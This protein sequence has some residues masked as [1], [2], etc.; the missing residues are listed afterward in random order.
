[1]CPLAPELEFSRALVHHLLNY[2]SQ[3]PIATIIKM[4]KRLACRLL[5]ATALP[6]LVSSRN[7]SG[8][9]TYLNPVLP[10]WHSDPSCINVD[11]TFFCVTSTFISFPGLPVYA[12]N[13][14][15]NWKLISHAWNREN[16]LPGL[17]WNTTGQQDGMYAPTIRY[18]DGIFYVICEYLGI[19]GGI[20]GTLF[21]TTDPFDDAS[22]SDPVMFR[23]THID[24]DLFW[25]DDGKVYMATH[26]ITMQELDIETGALT[27]EVNIWNGT[28]GVW[29]EGPHIYKRDGWYYLLIAEGGT[30]PDHAVTV[31]RS[32]D[33]YG[34]YEPSPFNPHLTNRGTDEWIQTVGHADLFQDG[35]GKWWG[36]ALGTR[37]GP[38]YQ[39]YP[40]GREAF[41]FPVT[42][43]KDEWPILQ[44]IRGRMEGWALPP[45]DEDLPG[46]Y[47]PFNSDDD[48]YDFPEGSEIPKN[49]VYWRV[50]RDGAVS[51]KSNGL[52]L[53]PSRN[54]LTGIPQVPAQIDLSGQRGLSFIGRRQ[55]HSLF[56][57]SVDL[58]FNPE[59]SGQEAGVTVFLTQVN[60]IDLGI[61]YL[62]VGTDYQTRLRFRAIGTSDVPA[63]RELQVP[64]EW[65]S[66]PVRLGIK[67]INATHYAFS[68][69][70]T[71]NLDLELQV[72][73]SSAMVVSGGNGSFVG[74]LVGVFNTCNGEGS[75]FEC[76]SDGVANFSRWRY[77]G[78]GQK[79]SNSEIVYGE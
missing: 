18:K 65:P 5:A 31:A 33:I 79:I 67:T 10:G 70:P 13:D 7:C 6:I 47:G 29:P 63:S 57:F 30:G 35:N 66:G 39:I 34:P 2:S 49:L 54:N 51:I 77:I 60:H 3:L 38:A 19:P 44:P 48:E 26:G 27:E 52:E 68:A 59:A 64:T 62:P 74:S 75:G 4:I 37:S 21:K 76:P 78:Q 15:I 20:R 41:L 24:P 46:G 14:L 8:N 55:T 23:P 56:D 9:S 40:M 36:M 43:N 58:T 16:Q 73:I 61:A 69:A 22:W 32:K 1:M 50:P 42:W 28:G 53:V 72:G 17:S 71:A 25:D 45:K 11:D 12:S